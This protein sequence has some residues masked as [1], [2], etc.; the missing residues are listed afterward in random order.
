MYELTQQD[1]LDIQKRFSYHPP[2]DDQ[3]ERYNRIRNCYV[4]HGEY[5]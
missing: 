1:L 4:Y 2:K 5:S 3:A